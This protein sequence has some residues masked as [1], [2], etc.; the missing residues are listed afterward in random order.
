MVLVHRLPCV[1][2]NSSSVANVVPSKAKPFHGEKGL[3]KTGRRRDI[4]SD[5]SN[6]NDGVPLCVG[7][8]SDD[9]SVLALAIHGSPQSMA[10]DGSYVYL[11]STQGLDKIGT[12][13]VRHPLDTLRSK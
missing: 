10:T 11:H 4:D 2:T 3:K 13:Y 5:Y 8:K 7:L 9:C 1:F 12:G 6:G